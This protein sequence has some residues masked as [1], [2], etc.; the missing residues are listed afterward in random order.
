MRR[1][2]LVVPA[3]LVLSLGACGGG[4]DDDSSAGS[5]VDDATTAE[6]V[7]TIEDSAFGGVTSVPEG[8]EVTVEN[9]D[10]FQHT[11]TPDKDGDFQPASLQGG[12]SATIEM[13]GPGTYGYH[14]SIHTTMTGEITVEG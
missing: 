6:Q 11:F 12:A 3:L 14:C 10:D 9:K 13:P 7:I 5:G 1:L 4:G 8:S 2:L